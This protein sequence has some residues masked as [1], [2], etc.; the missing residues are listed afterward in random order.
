LLLADAATLALAWG[1]LIRR[2][3]FRRAGRPSGH[4]ARLVASYGIRAQIGGVI[5]LMNLRLDFIIL[6]VLAGPAVLGVYAVASKFAELVKVLGMSVTYVLYPKFARDGRAKATSSA[7]RLM[8]KA[9]LLTAA[10]VVPLWLAAGVVIPA[11]YGSAFKPAVVPAQIILLGLSVDGIAA[12]ITAYL[13]GVGR[14]GLNSLAMTAGLGVTVVLDL[15][16]I[17]RFEAVGAATASAVAYVTST[18]VL[19][20]IYW[21]LSRSEP[22]AA[23]EPARVSLVDG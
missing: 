6:N 14:P 10:A 7:R 22:N 12:V 13:Y 20:A 21:W 11:L 8:P 16:L 4:L 23:S 2:G 18:C 1:R 9:G 15:L 5:T 3:F 17:P 19:V